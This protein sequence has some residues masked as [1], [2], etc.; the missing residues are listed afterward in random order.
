MNRAV[1]DSSI[2]IGAFIRPN[3][4]VAGMIQTLLDHPIE[5]CVSNAILNETSHTLLTKKQLR[6]Y[7]TYGDDDVEAW[8]DWLTHTATAM[9]PAPGVTNICHDPL[10]SDREPTP[11]PCRAVMIRVSLYDR[12]TI[13]RDKYILN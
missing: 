7:A 5:L 6:R 10:A 4:A 9:E 12:L 13:N 11:Q 1:L 8:M 2:L 3:G